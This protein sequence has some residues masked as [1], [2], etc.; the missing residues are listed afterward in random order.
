MNDKFELTVAE[1]GTMVRNLRAVP[2]EDP[3]PVWVIDPIT[4]RWV[5]TWPV[6][7]LEDGRSD[8]DYA[9]IPDESVETL[10]EV[11]ESLRSTRNPADILVAGAELQWHADQARAAEREALATAL[12]ATARDIIGVALAG[13]GQPA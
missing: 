3:V 9:T 8:L 4:G 2:A 6:H 1:V 10:D 11:A 7:P 13:L 5:P 12:E